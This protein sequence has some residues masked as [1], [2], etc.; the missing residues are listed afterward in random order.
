[1]Y[2]IIFELDLEKNST[3]NYE[4]LAPLYFGDLDTN[5][6]SVEMNVVSGLNIF[7]M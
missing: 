1:M 4:I 5:I 2:H 7:N 3:T 6:S